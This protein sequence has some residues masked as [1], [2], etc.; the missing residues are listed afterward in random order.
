MT[1]PLGHTIT[2]EAPA[3][4][5]NVGIGF[6]LLGLALEGPC[7]RVTVRHVA[8]DEVKVVAITGDGGVLP[9]GVTENTAAIAAVATMQRAGVQLGLEIELHKG[10]PIGSGLGSSAASAAAASFAVNGLLGSPLR[11]AELV[12]PCLEAEARVSGR[13]ADNI[14]PALLGGLIL[15]KSL[16]P[17]ELVRLPVPEGL[18]TAVVH[19][20]FVLE[21]RVSREALP[22]QVSLQDMVANSGQLACFVSACYSRDLGLIGRSIEDPVV[23]P[24]RA[25]LIP[26]AVEVME[27]ARKAG[28]LGSSLSGSGPSVFAL[29]HSEPIARRVGSAMAQAFA[30]AEL[31]S[32]VHVCAA[33]NPGTRVV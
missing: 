8:G 25:P 19:P 33:D 17:L 20:H 10:L 14:A 24:A 23:T 1:Y 27:A 9:Q 29:C 6:D 11:R 3:S 5:G 31:D 30:Q 28:A 18:F 15:V 16:Q 22:D 7:D 26:G 21:T 2:A 32:T 13:H 12:E 4:I